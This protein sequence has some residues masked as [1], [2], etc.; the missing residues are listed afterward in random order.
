MIRKRDVMFTGFALFAMLFGAGNLIFP[1]MLGHD[2]G[3]YWGLGAVGFVITGVGVPLLGL[4]AAAHEGE[5][6]HFSNRVSPLFAKMYIIVLILTIGFFLAMPRTGA[7]AY[8]MTLKNIGM[9][10]PIYK[11]GF[12]ALYFV[13]TWF[14][15]LSSQKVVDRIGKILTP[16]LLFLLFLIIYYGIKFPYSSLDLGELKKEAFGTGFIQGY[17]TMDTLATIVY[18]AVIVKSI[19]RGRDLSKREENKFLWG[20]SLVAVGLLDFVYVALTYIGAMF[21]GVDILQNTELLIYIVKYILGDLGNAVLGVAVAGACLTTAIG[22]VATVGDYFE[23]LLPWS[24]KTIVTITCIAG[25]IFSSFGVQTIIQLAIPVLV[26]LYP[27]SM[28]LIFLNLMKKY[29]TSNG[30]YRVLVGISF[31]FGLYELWNM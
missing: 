3:Q 9:T 31:C 12:L 11:Y 2:L 7:T 30:V 21:S 27:V 24:Y 29:I 25:F 5:L 14:F 15:S 10:E 1:P 26:V 19:Q 18:S 16:V 6:N 20:S 4:I 23:K 13:I 8:E 28:M 22:L 17:Q